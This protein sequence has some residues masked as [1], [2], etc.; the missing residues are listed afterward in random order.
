MLCAR[1]QPTGF[2]NA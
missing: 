1:F 2:Q